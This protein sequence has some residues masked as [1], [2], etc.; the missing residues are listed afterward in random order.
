[1][2]LSLVSL[3]CCVS[4]TAAQHLSLDSYQ[5][6]GQPRTGI[7]LI[8]LSPDSS[9]RDSEV[10]TSLEYDAERDSERPAKSS[11]S[12]ASNTRMLLE[13]WLVVT[14]LGVGFTA[15]LIITIGTIRQTGSSAV[16]PRMF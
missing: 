14:V 16:P 12:V 7:P 8:E 13:N 6:A 5:L 9:F 4:T 2:G 15:G 10:T 11:V 3:L 1:M